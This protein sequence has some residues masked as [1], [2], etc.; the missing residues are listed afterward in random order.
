[1]HGTADRH[2]II[3]RSV[4][5]YK[6]LNAHGNIRFDVIGL[7]S[8]PRESCWTRIREKRRAEVT[9]TVLIASNPYGRDPAEQESPS[10]TLSSP[11]VWMMVEWYD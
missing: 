9:P 11:L 6:L 5:P 7:I 1:M 4:N 10:P 2:S 8:I 3:R